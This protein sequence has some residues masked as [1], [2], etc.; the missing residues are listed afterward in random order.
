MGVGSE[1]F[2][3]VR[4]GR[5]ALGV[6]LKPS[7]YSQAVRNMEIAVAGSYETDAVA[8]PDRQTEMFADGST[9]DSE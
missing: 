6:E 8:E 3:A 9:M 7:Y 1:C 4:N 5:K 2:G